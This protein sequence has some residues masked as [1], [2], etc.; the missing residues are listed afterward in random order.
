MAKRLLRESVVEE[1]DGTYTFICPVSAGCG[2]SSVGADHIPFIS[3]K[4]DS[5][6]HAEERGQEHFD[7]H[8]TGADP[9]VDTK[10]MTPLHEFLAARN[11]VPNP[12]GTVTVKDLT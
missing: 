7:E 2:D 10:L 12:D 3:N 9:G 1:A 8:V 5:R 6:K 11:L 4:W